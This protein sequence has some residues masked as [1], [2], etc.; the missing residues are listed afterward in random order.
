VDVI[1]VID[2][3]H[4]Q[5]VRATGGDRAN[6]RPLSTPLSLT[7]DP[8]SVARGLVALHPF[9]ALYVA[10]LDGIEGRGR[11]GALTN[12]L[13]RAVPAMPVWLDCGATDEESVQVILSE[14]HVRVVMG[15]ESITDLAA[16]QRIVSRYGER[17]ILSLDFAGDT[18]RGLPKVLVDATVWPRHVIVMTLARVGA[19]RGPDVVR[20]AELIAR[21]PRAC[22]VYAAGGIRDA[23]DLELV[24][25]L[26]AKGA[27]VSTAL[28]A[29]TITADDLGKVTG[30]SVST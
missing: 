24:A 10:D 25:V 27:L 14:P 5:V 15:S 16:F 17:V 3:R 7:S 26:G 18:F 29:Q 1:P 8:A 21:A 4:R 2:V 28:H 23:H 12:V 19:G 20:L 11:D 30:R 13:A 22:N 6:Y 9:S